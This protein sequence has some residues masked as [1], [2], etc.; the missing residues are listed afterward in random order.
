MPNIKFLFVLV[1]GLILFPTCKSDTTVDTPAAKPPVAKK[2]IPIPKFDKEAA[3]NAV[4]K[5][6]AF[7]PRVP[8]TDGHKACKE[9]ILEEL[10]KSGA[11]IYQQD[12]QAKAYT[13]TVLNATNI[14]ASFNPE[15]KKRV[16]VAAHW[17]T[18][19][20]SDYDPDA[21]K[22][23]D[24]VPGA[25]DGG[26]GVAVLLGLAT[27]LNKTPID[28]GVDL[29]F[30]DAE[31]HGDS[32]G[33]ELSWCLGSQH[34]SKNPHVGGYKAKY[35]IL[36]DMVGSK[37]ARFPK[38]EISMSYA[39]NVTNKV[40]KLANNMGFGNYF[41]ND[42]VQGVTDDHLFVNRIAKIP[43]IDIINLPAGAKNR[44]GSHWHTHKDGIG[45]IDKNT[46][47][48]VGQTVLAVLY[49]ESN[50]KF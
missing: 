19:H 44:F 43:T 8:N 26:S 37:G 33:N 15:A 41:T 47:R 39:P 29:I 12:F 23:G 38:E 11:K 35:G 34:W 40:W 4:V 25:D 14:I 49:N 48:A 17:D 3:Y 18:R 45:V 42:L 2:Q 36:L 6:V 1:L 24:P 13:G 10:N 28:I 7:G 22:K 21:T 31:D 9:W 27:E 5:Q 32:K 50:G 46:L 30:F 16:F 20:I